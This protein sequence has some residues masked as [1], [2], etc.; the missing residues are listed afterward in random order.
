MQMGGRSGIAGFL[1]YLSQLEISL[2]AGLPLTKAISLLVSESSLRSERKKL[3][4]MRDVVDEGRS[5]LPALAHLLP[6]G[7]SYPF[8][9]FDKVPNQLA[10]I[11]SLKSYISAEQ[12]RLE[13][14]IR[15]LIYPVFLFFLSLLVAGILIVVALPKYAIFLEDMGT[16][17]PLYMRVLLKLS[18]AGTLALGE[19]VLFGV[20]IW[21]ICILMAGLY[22]RRVYLNWFFSNHYSQLWWVM[23]LMMSHGF[24]LQYVLHYL[25]QSQGRFATIAQDFQVAFDRCGSFHESWVQVLDLRPF[26]VDVLKMAQHSHQ[27]SSILLKLSEQSRAD[28]Q[29]KRLQRIR[30]WIPLLFAVVIIQIMGIFYLMM[31][32]VLKVL[33]GGVL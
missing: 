30:Y 5:L 17:L 16:E 15:A 18:G 29:L 31:T 25:A 12:G 27:L 3:L 1:Y 21:A 32:P 4:R 9:A 6:S 19:Q 28:V 2:L 14:L 10:G 20:L 22:A 11:Q 7:M 8:A 26:E 23:G 24:S 33:E 13:A